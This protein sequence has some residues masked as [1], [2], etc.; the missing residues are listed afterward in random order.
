MLDMLPLEVRSHTSR[1]SSFHVEVVSL[2][3]SNHGLRKV[4]PEGRKLQ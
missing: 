2:R 3:R 1:A 4:A